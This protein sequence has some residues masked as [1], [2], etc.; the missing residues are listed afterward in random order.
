M[1]IT[2]YNSEGAIVADP[3]ERARILLEEFGGKEVRVYDEEGRQLAIARRIM[4]KRHGVLSL[5]AKPR[6]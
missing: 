5:L 6:K 2:V 3:Y 1:T 4:K